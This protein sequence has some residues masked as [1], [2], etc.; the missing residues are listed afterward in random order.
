MPQSTQA[1]AVSIAPRVYYEITSRCNLACF[2]CNDAFGATARRINPEALL[3][4]HARFAAAFGHNGMV[5]SVVTGGEPTLH[6]DLPR[7]L[8]GLSGFGPV[9]LTTNGTLDTASMLSNAMRCFP[10]LTV[11]VSFDGAT[12]EIFEAIRGPGTWD[13]VVRFLRAMVDAG[14]GARICLSM[15]VM[16][17]NYQ[18]HEAI[19]ALAD[20]LG[21][22]MVYFPSLLPAGHAREFWDQVALPPAET[23][24]VLDSI[25]AMMTDDAT[26]VTV[27]SN[28]L[29]QI[30]V[31]LLHKEKAD[32]LTQFTL[33]VDCD[34][35]VMP[36]P[37]TGRK[38]VCLGAITDADVIERLPAQLEAMSAWFGGVRQPPK[39]CGAACDAH[40]YCQG[41]F[42]ASCELLAFPEPAVVRDA[43]MVMKHH[44]HNALTAQRVMAERN[45]R[46]PRRGG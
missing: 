32:C 45:L 38:D 40:P 11:Q 13:V 14:L 23:I 20:R 3:G 4:F 26:P 31:R 8:E 42:C 24:R 15:S 39:N 17:K 21:V 18:E 5:S 27:R 33:K 12:K 36:C 46:S 9:V 28:T 2:H 6:T 16:K 29:D 10:H 34:G 25:G 35:A 19:V 30:L 44:F 22:G 43:C 41:Q 37:A 7:I 1:N